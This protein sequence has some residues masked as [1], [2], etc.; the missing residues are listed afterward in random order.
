MLCTKK[1]LSCKTVE[2][3]FLLFTCTEIWVLIGVQTNK[4]KSRSHA[5]EF[6]PAAPTGETAT[7]GQNN[8]A[9]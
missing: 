8:A 1:T 9:K 6:G 4:A 7:G 2:R 3:F 5:R